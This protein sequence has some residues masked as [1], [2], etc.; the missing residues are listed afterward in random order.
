MADIAI[1]GTVLG[2]GS[3]NFIS[4]EQQRGDGKTSAIS[5]GAVLA[6]AFGG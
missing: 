5:A 1:A 2:Q 3:G 4:I 6:A